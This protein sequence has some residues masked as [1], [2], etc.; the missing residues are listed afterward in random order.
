MAD[1]ASPPSPEDPKQLRSRPHRAAVEF[2]AG[3]PLGVGGGTVAGGA[4]VVRGARQA[5]ELTR[6]AATTWHVG[7]PFSDHR[8]S[9][10]PSLPTRSPLRSA[11]LPG[12]RGRTSRWRRRRAPRGRAHEDPAMRRSNRC[13]GHLP[14]RARLGEPVASRRSATSRLPAPALRLPRAAERPDLSG[15]QSRSGTP[16]LFRAGASPFAGGSR[17]DVRGPC[18]IAG[19]A[20]FRPRPLPLGQARRVARTRRRDRGASRACGRSRAGR[21]PRG[22]SAAAGRRGGNRRGGDRWP[23]RQRRARAGEHCG[24]RAADDRVPRRPV[25][26]TDLGDRHG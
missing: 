12:D 15:S 23:S 16:R 7:P 22:H 14:R 17:R 13:P 20:P 21:G 9:C 5:V 25:P 6:D 19:T 8:R 3:A 1:A 2:G 26:R 4:Q 24:L 11:V 18:R 10:A